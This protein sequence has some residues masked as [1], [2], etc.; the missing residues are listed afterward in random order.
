MCNLFRDKIP[1]TKTLMFNTIAKKATYLS[2]R[3]KFAMLI[4]L[5]GNKTSTTK[6]F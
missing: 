6:N 3:F 1:T 2:M 5:N 4:K